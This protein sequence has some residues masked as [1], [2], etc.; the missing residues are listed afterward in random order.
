MQ[1]SN[2]TNNNFSEVFTGEN[3]KKGVK[4]SNGKVVIPALYDAV[5]FATS[6]LISINE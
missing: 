3:G 2:E 4:L 1:N 5:A 6:I